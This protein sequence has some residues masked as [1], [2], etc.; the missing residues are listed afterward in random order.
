[1]STDDIA[2]LLDSLSADEITELKA[3]SWR[4]VE[5][6]AYERF[7]SWRRTR[8]GCGPHAHPLELVLGILDDSLPD[9][10]FFRGY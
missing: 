10:P 2:E 4:A 9:S 8:A 1:L 6:C 3:L 7:V 5:D